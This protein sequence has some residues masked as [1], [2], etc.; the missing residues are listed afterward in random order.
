MKHYR[1]L[2]GG[3]DVDAANGE[4]F[5]SLNPTTGR[6]W[7]TLALGRTQDV[8]RAVRAAGAAFE[9]E[10]WRALSP[11]RRGR[12]LMRL[13]DLIADRADEIARIEVTD[14]GKLYKE[15]RAQLRVIPDWLYYFGG[16]ADKVEGRVIP[17]DRTS[18]LN[19]TLREPLGNTNVV[20]LTNDPSFDNQPSW[21]PDGT[22]ITFTSNRSGNMDIF[23]MNLDGSDLHNIT[24]YYADDY[25]PSW[26]PDGSKIVFV[27]SDRGGTFNTTEICVMN[28]G[29]SSLVNLTV[30]EVSDL[31][32]AWSPDGTMIVFSSDRDGNRDLYSM[33]ANGSNQTRMTVHP[34]EDS[35]A[36]WQLSPIST[37]IPT[38]TPTP[39]PSPTPQGSLPN[40]YINS[41]TDPNPVVGTGSAT[42]FHI[43]VSN[44]ADGYSLAATLTALLPAGLAFNS[45]N[46]SYGD[47][48]N[49]PLADGVTKVV[50]PLGD[51][52]PWEERSIS[53]NI[54]VNAT[55]GAT[56]EATLTVDSPTPEERYDDNSRV[57]SVQVAG[58]P[59]NDNFANAEAISG[60]TGNVT[61]TNEFATQEA[62]EPN[63]AN[64]GQSTTVWYRWTAPSSGTFAFDTRG[65]DFDTTL[66]IYT[67]TAVN[68]LTVVA[69]NDDADSELYS[70]AVFE[71]V[72]GGLYYLA[73]HTCSNVIANQGSINLS[74][75]AGTQPTPSPSPG[76]TSEIVFK[77]DHGTNVG[78][79]SMSADGSNQTRLTD[80][81]E[82]NLYPK[83][84]PDGQRIAFIS[85]DIDQQTWD[86]YTMNA[87]GLDRKLILHSTDDGLR[88]SVVNPLWSP[89]GTKLAFVA[90]DNQG[91]TSVYTI[92]S[93]GTNIF[94][95]TPDESIYTA[96]VW[97]PGGTKLLFNNHPDHNLYVI[98]ADGTNRSQ[99]T[100]R[101]S[102]DPAWSPDGE[103]ILFNSWEAN[104]QE[105]FVM[106]AD[107]SNQTQ[108]TDSSGPGSGSPGSAGN[109]WQQWSPDSS[110]IVFISGREDQFD[111]YL[112]NAD[113]SNQTRLTSL[114]RSFAPSYSPDGNKIGFVFS[115]DSDPDIY[116]IN[117]D[118]TNLTNL[119]NNPAYE[120]YFDWRPTHNTP[121]GSNVTVTQNS[122][123]VTLSNVTSAGSTTVTPIDPNTLQG[124]PGEYVINANS[125]AFEIHTTAIYSG[126][127][128]IAF[129][130]PGVN[131]PIAFSTL[132]VLH[133][134]PPP[135][136]HFVDRTILAPDSPSH[137]FA[138]RTVYARVTSLSPFIVLE[139]RDTTVP[140]TTATLSAPS[141]A[142][143]WHNANVTVTLAATDNSGGSGVQSITYSAAGAQN[144]ALTIATG[145]TSAITITSEGTTT[146]T[147][148]ATDAHG[149]V[150]TARSISVKLDKTA[151]SIIITSPTATAYLLRQVVT[152]AFQCTD[153]GSGAATC[154][155]PVANGATL[156]N[157]EVGAKTFTVN[158]TDVAGNTSQQS[159]NYTVTYGINPLFD[160]SKANRSGSTI[161]IK[162]EL[163]DA[164]ALNCSASDIVVT[165]TAV[166]RLSDMAPGELQDP[167]NAN[168][169][170]N[171][172]YTGGQY[173]FN[174]NTNGYATGTY[175]L[176]FQVSGDPVTHWVQFQVK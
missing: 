60:S 152:A 53:I 12:L 65:S 163:V 102:F 165:A 70:R 39:S 11:T 172:R 32:P 83:W 30:N 23:V 67:G 158:A 173:H 120:D 8:D 88:A 77:S 161:P 29:G 108:L 154:T 123:A 55:T 90:Q 9:S 126:P 143:G 110:H 79:F 95:V 38:P 101:V 124:V 160:Q 109:G 36:S 45:A 130:V 146:L 134:E 112:M 150:E 166:T 62:G 99:L 98:N 159:V 129:Q 13:A 46:S 72:G 37:P 68:A 170:S 155:G 151:P 17:L 118:G 6:Q 111:V 175:R 167:G 132:R 35:R 162:L 138:T 44:A 147:Y 103:K 107:G 89:D 139:S 41:Y 15:M 20:N 133:G 10:A 125:L 26:S 104:I 14:N 80:K 87:D 168:P 42:D 78:V 142:A 59:S 51:F 135:V 145:N 128:T 47:C 2:I 16:L 94:N 81:A 57:E 149:N 140:L 50:C 176:D 48:S 52:N 69:S 28:A 7:A 75:G 93:D 34:A 157:T 113:G 18:V 63:H 174:L 85:S 148:S 58:R 22:K 74:W 31:T 127:I 115:S 21:S 86:I 71:A 43:S 117:V 97:S 64:R 25:Y 84:S 171:F 1:L 100:T 114:G 153:G 105:I 24:N 136:S 3:E 76:L 156:T 33:N 119:T 82:Y 4:T 131:D 169:D 66:G 141:N 5:E 106:N 40:L 96:P 61:G 92:N 121:A 122:V 144:V 73:V 164:S 19:Y 27:S 137:D 56:L 54:T 116:V 49:E 91:R